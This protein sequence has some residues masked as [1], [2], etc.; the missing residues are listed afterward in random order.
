MTEFSAVSE[1]DF[2]SLGL[3]YQFFCEWFDRSPVGRIAVVRESILECLTSRYPDH[4]KGEQFC[5]AIYANLMT[6]GNPWK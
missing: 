6:I 3:S 4:E 1:I 5:G 2:L